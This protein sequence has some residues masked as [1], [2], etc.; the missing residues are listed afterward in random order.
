[1]KKLRVIQLG[2]DHDHAGV[3]MMSLKR[4]SDVF[5]VVGFSRCG[6]NK[7][8]SKQYDGVREYS[9]EE[10][11]NLPDIDA[12][13]IE[14]YDLELTKYAKMALE[15]GL[16]VQMDKPGGADSDEFDEMVDYAKERGL[17]FSMGY[18]YRFNPNVI[19]LKEK[20]KSGALGE[21]I[22]VEAHMDCFHNPDKRQWLND[23]PGGM[24]RF[25]GCHLVDLVYSIM[26]EPD[27]VIPYNRCTGFDGVTSLDY[28]FAVFEYKTGVSFVKTSAIEPG[29]FMRRQIVVSGTKGTY[30]IRP[31]EFY[32]DGIGDDFMFSKKRETYLNENG[33]SVWSAH[34]PSE[35]SKIFNRYNGMLK[36]FAKIVRREIENPYDYEYEKRLHRLL[37]KACGA[38]N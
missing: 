32:E 28:G 31:I 17:C 11:L 23:L 13:V 22:S 19:D 6:C 20:I 26:G 18:M 8:L 15:K 33:G 1:M 12:A 21:I 7:E 25:L 16:H 2:V 30:E 9:T 29:G 37:Q 38:E 14:T 3:T 4:L 34:I 36:N 27:K 35:K 5:E 10:L 24:M